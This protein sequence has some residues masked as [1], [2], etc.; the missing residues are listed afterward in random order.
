MYFIMRL[1]LRWPSLARCES[2]A[3]TNLLLL[4]LLITHSQPHANSPDEKK[5]LTAVRI[6]ASAGER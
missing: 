3:T 2:L 4:L 6:A 5:P 1:H